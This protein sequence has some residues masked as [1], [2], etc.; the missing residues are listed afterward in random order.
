[1]TYLLQKSAAQ[2]S[3]TQSFASHLRPLLAHLQTEQAPRQRSHHLPM[4]N[5]STHGFCERTEFPKPDGI[6]SPSQWTGMPLSNP[7]ADSSPQT[8]LLGTTE[9][10]SPLFSY[11][12]LHPLGTQIQNAPLPVAPLSQQAIGEDQRYYPD[13]CT[14]IEL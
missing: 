14:H 12:Q 10:A 13:R 9:S 5:I 3:R 1:M 8:L 2:I 11:E 6:K 4:A 7:P